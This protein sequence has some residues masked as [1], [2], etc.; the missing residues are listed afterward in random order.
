MSINE[1]VQEQK[2]MTEKNIRIKRSHFT[3][4]RKYYKQNNI[5][6]YKEGKD[7]NTEKRNC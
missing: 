7:K 5:K 1:A 2:Q 4:R 3:G 6:Y